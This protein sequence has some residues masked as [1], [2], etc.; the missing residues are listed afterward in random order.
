MS[1]APD[2]TLCIYTIYIYIY[3]NRFRIVVES[4]DRTEKSIQ[5][6]KSSTKNKKSVYY[7]TINLIDLAGS[8]SGNVH[9][10]VGITQ[11]EMRYINKVIYIYI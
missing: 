8:E 11:H 1:R 2:P 9:S 10:K 7:S 4:R 5:P 3:I 6:N